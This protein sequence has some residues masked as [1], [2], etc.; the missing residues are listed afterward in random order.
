MTDSSESFPL[1]RGSLYQ[2]RIQ[3]V[4]DP[5]WSARLEGLQIEVQRCTDGPSCTVLSGCIEDQAALNGVLSTLYAL[6][7]RLLSVTAA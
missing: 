3:G 7:F 6:G 2:I 4:L 5:S 1:E